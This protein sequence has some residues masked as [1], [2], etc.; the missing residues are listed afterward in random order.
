MLT[1]TAHAVMAITNVSITDLA[2]IVL[3]L[4]AC[5]IRYA[6]SNRC[7]AACSELAIQESV[8]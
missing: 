2:V 3:V 5:G 6:R 1:S 7:I 4:C 8:S